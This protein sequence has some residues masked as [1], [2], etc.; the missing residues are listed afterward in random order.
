ML[1][2]WLATAANGSAKRPLSPKTTTCNEVNANKRPHITE[3]IN[4]ETTEKRLK[5]DENQQNILVHGMPLGASWH[6]AL[7]KELDKPYFQKLMQFLEREREAK[8]HIFPPQPL[9]FNWSL[10]CSIDDIR[11]VIIGQDP[12]HNHGQA[13]GLSFSVPK[14]V[15]PP[16]S[17]VNMFK[18]LQQ[19]AAVVF[20]HPGHG[21]LEGWAKQ[22]VLLLNA[23]L[24]VEAHKANAHQGKGWE[25][26]TDAVIKALSQRR[27]HVVYLLWGK[28][29]EKKGKAIDRKSNCVLVGPHPSP[30]SAHRG[31]F[32]CQHFSKANAYLEEHGRGSIAWSDL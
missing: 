23:V 22:G 20:K 32:G 10:P 27:K 18:E 31:F 11:V 24:T 1:K 6:E 5:T 29:A 16:P 2:K 14:G 19:D 13:H 28:Y 21:N 9:I 4:L 8:K 7:Y 3:N 26:F 12:Y 30:L 15:P 17:L 25:T